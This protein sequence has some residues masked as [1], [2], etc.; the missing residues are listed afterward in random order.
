M[1]KSI[2][3]ILT[4]AFVFG[5]SEDNQ[6]INQK[7]I[8][9]W[10]FENRTDSQGNQIGSIQNIKF[11]FETLNFLGNDDDK[12]L[13][14]TWTLIDS[15]LTIKATIKGEDQWNTEEYLIRKIDDD[16]LIFTENNLSKNEYFNFTKV[17]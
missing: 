1:K 14:G 2:L 16:K 9:T 10:K 7:L 3:L 15:V 13:I 11:T 17:K 8:G 12:Q 5:C 6:T 4:I